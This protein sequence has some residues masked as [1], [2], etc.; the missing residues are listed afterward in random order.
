MTTIYLSDV[1][2]SYSEF[3]NYGNYEDTNTDND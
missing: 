2:K 3:V 1:L